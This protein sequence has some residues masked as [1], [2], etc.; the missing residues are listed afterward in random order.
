MITI[1]TTLLGLGVMYLFLFLMIRLKKNKKDKQRWISYKDLLDN[2]KK[3]VI[4]KIK[5]LWHR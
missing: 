2:K 1:L 3:R 4:N 5:R